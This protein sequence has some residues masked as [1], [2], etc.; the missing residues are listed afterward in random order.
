M[1]CR[2][3]SF[4][5]NEVHFF[6]KQHFNKI[7]IPSKDGEVIEVPGSTTEMTTVQFME[8][9]DRIARW[10][11]EYLGVAIPPPNTDLKMQF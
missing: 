4:Q 10:A 11:A 1:G 9:V 8:Y 6:L 5:L 3:S 7:Q 2:V